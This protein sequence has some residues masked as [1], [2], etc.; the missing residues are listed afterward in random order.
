[1]CLFIRDGLTV[2]P[3]SRP[4]GAKDPQKHMTAEK[5]MC[6][7]QSLKSLGQQNFLSIVHILMLVS[8]S[9]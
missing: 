9:E 2:T 5:M 1:M 6:I 7:L 3:V 8:F 4:K